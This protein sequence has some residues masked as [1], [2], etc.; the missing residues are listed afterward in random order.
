V[1]FSLGFDSLVTWKKK[2]S[3]SYFSQTV[4]KILD[5]ASYFCR[6]NVPFYVFGDVLSNPL[7]GFFNT[8]LIQ[9]LR[10]INVLQ[11]I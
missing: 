2:N 9:K 1:K 8:T 6:T 7:Q 4:K 11:D 3:E 5:S 10:Q